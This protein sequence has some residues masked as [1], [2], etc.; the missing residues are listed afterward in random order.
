MNNS[1]PECAYVNRKVEQVFILE[2]QFCPIGKNCF[3][4][5][6]I[7]STILHIIFC[8]RL[9][10]YNKYH[11]YSLFSL[12]DVICLWIHLCKWQHRAIY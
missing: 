11:F 5:A 4:K 7:R 8:I 12:H 10:V 6:P 2:N 9:C 1:V 3:I